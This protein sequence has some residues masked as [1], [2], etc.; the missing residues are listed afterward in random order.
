MFGRETCGLDFL[1]AKFKI[2]STHYLSKD[3]AKKLN[4]R[5]IKPTGY[6]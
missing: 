6:S 2:Q 1:Q 3:M 5:K 4:N